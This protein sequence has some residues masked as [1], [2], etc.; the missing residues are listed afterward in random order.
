MTH[1]LTFEQLE[2]DIKVG[3]DEKVG[4]GPFS[5]EPNAHYMRHMESNELKM[6]I[7]YYKGV[8]DYVVAEPTQTGLGALTDH[9][10]TIYQNDTENFGILCGDSYI[11]E[12]L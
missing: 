4:A 11:S 2:K 10:K 5:W 1:G 6:S 7:N 3:I 12:Y 9:G 8:H